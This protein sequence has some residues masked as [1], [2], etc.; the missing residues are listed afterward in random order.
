MHTIC[1]TFLTVIVLTLAALTTGGQTF[2]N[3]TAAMGL[4]PANDGASW[5]DVN[6]DGWVDLVAGAL[7]INE[8]GKKFVKAGGGGSLLSWADFDND[9]NLDW[10]NAG[11]GGIG[12]GNGDGTFAGN[13]LPS[14]PADI[15]DGGTCLDINGDG[16]VDVYWT[17]YENWG[18][19]NGYPDS[20]FHNKGGRTFELVWTQEPPVF[21]GRGTTAADYNNDGATDIYVSDY[22]LCGNLLW[23]N[24][25]SLKAPGIV[26]ASIEAGAMGGPGNQGGGHSIGASFGDLDSDGY[27]D[28]FAGNF[29]HG[30]Q[31][32][33]QCLRN[34]G[35]EHGYAFENKGTCGVVYQ[36]S[37][38]SPALGD[39]DNDGDLDL[40]F[41]TV[42]GHNHSKFF[43]SDGNWGFSEIT[44]PA[45]LGGMPPTTQG[46]WGDFDNDGDLDLATGGRLYRNSGTGNNWLKVRL[47]GNASAGSEAGGKVNRA[48]LGAVARIKLG[49]KTITR[50][51]ESSTGR[52]NTNDM[53]L[54]FGLGEREEDVEIE[55]SWP[56]TKKK[57]IAT[58]SVNTTITV[59]CS[60][61]DD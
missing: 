31:P 24:D 34:R 19:V 14:K 5:V 48:A 51:V 2:E 35:P 54:H 60:V 15:C 30:G 26:F 27:I 1:R 23:K 40:Y 11:G 53:T 36:E 29:A 6:N 59:V 10:F 3:V 52:S 41:T 20:I 44:G 9:G 45:G 32:Q 61:S 16:F 56:Y 47:Q 43:K 50:H 57:Q 49:D 25:G 38:A 39:F 7:W 4:S 8:E 22:R 37:Y 18:V 21:P 46:A 58:A 33:S 17:G 13:S 42:Y 28:L 55:I 12:F